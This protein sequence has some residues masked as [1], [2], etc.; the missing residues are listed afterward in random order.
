[1]HNADYMTSRNDTQAF[2]DHLLNDEE[3][4]SYV[5]KVARLEDRSGIAQALRQKQIDADKKKAE[6]H[7]QRQ[8]QRE[9]VRSARIAEIEETREKLVLEEEEIQG[10]KV[11]ALEKQLRFHREE[12]NKYQCQEKLPPF[13][14]MKLKHQKVAELQ[15]AVLR[16]KARQQQSNPGPGRALASAGPA[17]L[18]LAPELSNIDDTFYHSDDDNLI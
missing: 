9:Q 8:V 10:L 18:A 11:P 16:Y 2:A 6:A 4:H 7:R 3:D 17:T 13:K 1:M 14:D 15:K 5:M 12:E